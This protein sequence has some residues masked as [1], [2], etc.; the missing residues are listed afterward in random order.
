MRA[1]KDLLSKILFYFQIIGLP[2]IALVGFFHA[3]SI[4]RAGGNPPAAVEPAMEPAKA[5]YE[6]FVAGSGLIISRNENVAIA[7]QAS[8]VI[9]KVFVTV[10]Q[11]I[12]KNDPLFQLDTTVAEATL[13]RALAQ[14]EA[15]QRDFDFIQSVKDKR[16]V[17]VEEYTKRLNALKVAKAVSD[18]SKAELEVLTVTAPRDGTVLKINIR[19]GEFAP[20]NI[21]TNPLIVL[22]DLSAL[23][24][25]VDVD[26]NDAWRIP[27]AGAKAIGALRG[28]GSIKTD[29]KFVR[30]EPY[31]VP[32]K[33]LTGDN[34]ERVDTRVLQLMFEVQD[35]N[36]PAFV[37]QLMDVFIEAKPNGK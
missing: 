1:L 32:K 19:E 15:S 20:A 26:E 5:P 8:G 16:A 34:S 37:G 22:G 7:S 28:N 3:A 10:G 25:Q 36:F 29:L 13:K 11:K 27:S 2:L 31:V 4:V 14:Q 12:K 17:S 23:W 30:F 33:S 24:I 18:Q 9:E 21:N 35:P 6:N